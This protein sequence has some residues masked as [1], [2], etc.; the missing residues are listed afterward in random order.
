MV[1]TVMLMVAVSI[2]SATDQSALA[3][4]IDTA[5]DLYAAASYREALDT[6]SKV[7]SAETPPP[8]FYEYQGLC[9]FALGRKE[10]ASDAFTRLVERD[11][12]F[13]IDLDGLAPS[14]RTLFES[15]R[16][17]TLPK[18][19]RQRFAGARQAFE[20]GDYQAASVGFA[21][22]GRILDQIAAL[23]LATDDTKDLA[24]LASGFAD[25]VEAR[26]R[27]T[28][29]H[30]ASSVAPANAPSIGRARAPRVV[31]AVAVSRPVPPWPAKLPRP[32]RQVATMAI[33]IDATGTVSSAKM[34]ETINPTYDSM[35]TAAVMTWRYQP[36]TRDGQ[37]TES[38][39][40]LRIELPR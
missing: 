25:L 24:T 1:S 13:Q 23:G 36:A 8:S 34:N 6:L 26:L 15:V 27:P 29:S 2:G 7:D 32:L 38:T 10:E 39:Q 9:L 20:R 12:L 37:A 16:R 5:R 28:V 4:S 31:A 17:E 3:T 14:V 35:L 19:A 22:V 30:P 40:T 11:P 21:G 18:A 33:V